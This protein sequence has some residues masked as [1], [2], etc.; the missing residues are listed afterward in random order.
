MKQKLQTFKFKINN[1][2]TVEYVYQDYD[3]ALRE[4]KADNPGA[5][6]TVV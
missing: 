6:V 2:P 3:Q 1:G 5:T 4:A